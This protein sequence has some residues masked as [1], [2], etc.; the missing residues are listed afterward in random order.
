MGEKITWIEED[1]SQFLCSGGILDYR[2]VCI[3]SRTVVIIHRNLEV[4]A[5][6]VGIR[7]VNPEALTVSPRKLEGVQEGQ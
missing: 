7:R 2:E 5:L 6:K 4:P 3:T 1:A